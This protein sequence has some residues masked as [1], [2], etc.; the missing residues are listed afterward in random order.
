MDNLI[1]K[2]RIDNH[3]ELNEKLLDTLA[4]VPE[5]IYPQLTY[6]DDYN[7]DSNSIVPEEWKINQV[8][9]NEYIKTYPYIEYKE[10]FLDA[11][12]C[13]LKE[14]AEFHIQPEITGLK[15]RHNIF[16]MWYHQMIKQDN[17]GWHNHQKCQWSGIYFVEVQEQKYITEFLNLETQEIIQPKAEVGDMLI[18]PSWM[19]H[20]APKIYNNRKTVIVW[21]MDIYYHYE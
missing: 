7:H 14:H 8:D 9:W 16:H 1:Y 10:I 15:Y 12:K 11:I 13:K 20:R 2:Y 3:K 6:K 17:V 21:N 5:I 19:L 4:L 18:F